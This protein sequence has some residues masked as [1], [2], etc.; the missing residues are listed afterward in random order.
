MPWLHRLFDAW[1]DYKRQRQREAIEAAEH[2][3]NTFAAMAEFGNDELF[4]ED[5]DGEGHAKARRKKF[6][7]DKKDKKKDKKKRRKDKERDGHA[8]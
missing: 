1:E 4:E 7:H 3:A 6:K 8:R 2:E 5:E